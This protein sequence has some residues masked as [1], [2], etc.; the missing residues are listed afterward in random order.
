MSRSVG[1]MML[2]MPTRN[3]SWGAYDVVHIKCTSVPWYSLHQ[4]LLKTRPAAQTTLQARACTRFALRRPTLKE[5]GIQVAPESQ[6]RS[7]DLDANV[8]ELVT[9]PHYVASTNEFE[10][11]ASVLSM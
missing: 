6:R 4:L 9:L 1:C 11:S 5:L 3:D 10:P 7:T 8:S 2:D